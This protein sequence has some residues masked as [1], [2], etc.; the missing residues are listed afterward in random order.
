MHIHYTYKINI[1]N[2]NIKDFNI[3][4]KIEIYENEQW[5]ITVFNFWRRKVHLAFLFDNAGALRQP[6]SCDISLFLSLMCSSILYYIIRTYVKNNEMRKK[7]RRHTPCMQ[8]LRLV[9]LSIIPLYLPTINIQTDVTYIK[10][11]EILI[12]K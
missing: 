9:E 3:W 4:R 8:C 5:R 11:R 2:N 6:W 10:D 7:I 12:I 1:K